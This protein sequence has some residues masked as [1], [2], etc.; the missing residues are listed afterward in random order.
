[1]EKISQS[2]I[3]KPMDTKKV[4]QEIIKTAK[5]KRA[6]FAEV[7]IAQNEF[8]LKRMKNGQ[9]DQPPA[10]EHWDIDLALVKAGRRKS[11]GFDNPLFAKELIAKT[12]QQMEFLPEQEVLIPKEPF[13]P[14][15]QP[16]GLYDTKTAQLAEEHL[17]AANKKIADAL[18]KEGLL[19]SGKI[20]QGRGELSYENSIGTGQSAQFTL[21]T[22]AFYAF[23]QQDSSI[24]AYASSGGTSIDHIDTQR[25]I[26]EL[27]F[28]C[29]LQR[30]QK[31]VDLFKGKKDGEDMQ[32]DVI[33]EPY[34]LEPVFGWLGFFGFNGLFVEHGESF[35]SGKVGQQIMDKNISIADHPDDPNNR[36]I[37]FPFDFE[38]RPRKKLQLIEQGIAK[39]AV[40]DSAM[41]SRFGKHPTGN[42]LPPSA[43]SQGASPFDIAVQGGQDTLEG[44]IAN[45][46]NPTLWITKAHYL[47]I[48]HNQTATMTGIGHHGVFLIEN[49]GKTV[50]PAENVRF[51]QNMVEAFS[52]VEALS[53]SRLVFD[54]M[55]LS[56][57]SGVVAP[58]MKIKQFRLIGSTTRTT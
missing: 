49:N 1:M 39:T 24:S 15:S 31:R 26:D 14:V 10:G 41:A 8:S 43:K 48:K 38:G 4:A 47:A 36:G 29:K 33:L 56:F 12:L 18:G 23:D 46:K 53:P 42:A 55:S 58:A 40:Y 7:V 20:A 21:A 45:S 52:R 9:V 28:K 5:Q 37:G 6:E 19:L 17:F 11:V 35:V 2:V 3:V 54:P 44:M 22:A 51:E 32:I 13:E 57:P 30:G 50:T 27:I 25:I 16:P 34:F